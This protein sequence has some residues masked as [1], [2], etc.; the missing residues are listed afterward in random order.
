MPSE[1][2]GIQ[3][4]N[5]G[6]VQNERNELLIAPAGWWRVFEHIQQYC[7]LVR[8]GMQLRVE[9]TSWPRVWFEWRLTLDARRQMIVHWGS[10]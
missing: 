7:S 1:H 5:R 8:S 3:R 2:G 10:A 9:S 4:D 6:G